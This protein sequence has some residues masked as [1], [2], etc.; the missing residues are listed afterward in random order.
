MFLKL[1]FDSDV[2]QLAATPVTNRRQDAILPHIQ[3]LSPALQKTAGSPLDGKYL[4][5]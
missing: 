3:G 2:R 5:W 4:L 1:M